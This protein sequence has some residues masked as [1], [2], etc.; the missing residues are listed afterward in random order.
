MLY[1][2]PC[3]LQGKPKFLELSNAH[4]M[5][6]TKA[7]VLGEWCKCINYR[8]KLCHSPS[9]PALPPRVPSPSPTIP[10][11]NPTWVHKACKPGCQR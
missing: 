1:Y 4:I 11:L 2:L 5:K 8:G 7:H 9:A 3:N 6:G 10:P